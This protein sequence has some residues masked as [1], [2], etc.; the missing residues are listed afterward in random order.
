MIIG[1]ISRTKKSMVGRYGV[2]SLNT[3]KEEPEV[4]TREHFLARKKHLK[5]SHFSLKQNIFQNRMQ[6]KNNIYA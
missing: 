2:V 5:I 1:L 3:R 4:P 6:H